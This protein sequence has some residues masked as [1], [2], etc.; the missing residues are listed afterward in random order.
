M[1]NLLQ[2]RCSDSLEG[3]FIFSFKKRM[4]RPKS[5]S[6]SKKT[7]EQKSVQEVA[8]EYK[9]RKAE[10]VRQ[11]RRKESELVKEVNRKVDLPKNLRHYKV[12]GIKRYVSLK[13]GETT[14]GSIRVNEQFAYLGQEQG[15]YIFVQSERGE[16][17]WLNRYFLGEETY[18][19][20]GK[21]SSRRTEKAKVQKTEKKGTI[22]GNFLF[23]K[24]S[25]R[26]GGRES[27]ETGNASLQNIVNQ[28]DTSSYSRIKSSPK[29]AALIKQAAIALGISGA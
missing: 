29:Y 16:K 26:G 1:K 12:K 27:R 14:V 20:S 3:A 10:T 13:S 8:K 23:G 24:P 21:S 19:G 4:G 15:K 25:E 9:P 6:R 17:G 28:F 22:V 5:S 11:T 18:D 2:Y 7:S